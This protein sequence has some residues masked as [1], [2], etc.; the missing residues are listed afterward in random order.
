MVKK[1]PILKSLERILK[2]WMLKKKLKNKMF[3]MINLIKLRILN[4]I[5]TL[6]KINS[7]EKILGWILNERNKWFENIII[8]LLNKYLL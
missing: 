7:D 5:I 6:L 1:K 3:W 8:I 4:F 2:R